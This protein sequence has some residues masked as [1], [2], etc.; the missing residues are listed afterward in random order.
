V[1]PQRSEDGLDPGEDRRR[2]SRRWTWFDPVAKCRVWGCQPCRAALPREGLDSRAPL[3]AATSTPG[4]RAPARQ[5]VAVAVGRVGCH[6]A[7]VTW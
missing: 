6:A 1:R 5:A 2:F 3:V 4:L 7:T